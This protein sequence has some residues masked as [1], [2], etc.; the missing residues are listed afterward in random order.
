M[1]IVRQTCTGGAV[2][3]GKKTGETL[4]EVFRCG[5]GVHGVGRTE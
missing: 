2:V 3:M 4:E 5:E 1:M